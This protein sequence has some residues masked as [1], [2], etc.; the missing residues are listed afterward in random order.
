MAS[1]KLTEKESLAIVEEMRQKRLSSV[2]DFFL[3]MAKGV[4]T[5][6]PGFL[7][8]VADKAID[9]KNVSFG[10]FDRSA[11]LFEKMTGIKSKSGSG[12]AD[13]L[14]GGMTNPIG[15]GKAVLLPAFMA[16]KTLGE[17]K[18][19]KKLL[20]SGRDAKEVFSNLDIYAD[21][22]TGGLKTVL[23]DTSA[24]FIPGTVQTKGYTLIYKATKQKQQ[25]L[26]AEL[27][28]SDTLD[29]LDVLDHPELYNIALETLK[30]LKVRPDI[31]G[32]GGGSFDPNTGIISLQKNRSPQELKSVLL[33]EI[34]HA[35][36]SDLSMPTGGNK[37]Q[38]LQFSDSL[39]S[40]ISKLDAIY[41]DDAIRKSLSLDETYELLS[42]RKEL[43][44]TVANAYKLYK[45]IPG[46]AEAR[47]VQSLFS[48]PALRNKLPLDYYDV[49][50]T[51][52]LTV[53]PRHY[54]KV[55]DTE[56]IRQLLDYVQSLPTP[57]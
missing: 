54:P 20:D 7:M 10:E 17:L 48:D 5:D 49:P 53:E 29:L 26:G 37:T 39:D 56:R 46:E 2:K 14:I 9:P 23:P 12:G 33:H 22:I 38:F 18:S 27:A 6:L 15:V 44:N 13:E 30:N 24:K 34:Q 28:S 47:A 8:D 40:A 16:G 51:D 3:G 31:T 42:T 43:Q 25:I 19:A 41:N 21:P 45:R 52:L 11:E 55:D 32:F 36:Q 35:L 57:K 1:P 50:L 4:T